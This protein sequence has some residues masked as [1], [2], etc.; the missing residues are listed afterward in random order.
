MLSAEAH[1]DDVLPGLWGSVENVKSSILVLHN[2]D[3]HLGSVRGAHGAGDLAFPSSLCVHS[4]DGLL[5]DLDGGPNTSTYRQ[6]V[7]VFVF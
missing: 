3:I 5:S 2:V 4:N 1:A 7:C 6:S